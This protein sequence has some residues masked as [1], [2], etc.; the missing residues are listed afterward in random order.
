MEAADVEINEQFS[1]ALGI[2][3][4]GRN[5]F[6][7]GKAGTGK[8]TLLDYFRNTTKK[9]VAVLAP[10]GVAA[11]NING[12][13][14]HSFFGFGPDIT[15]DK[16]KIFKGEQKELYNIVEAIV[17]DEVSMVRADLL[18]C[19]DRFLRLNRTDKR[20]FGGI[21]MVFF[22]DLYQL[23]PVV[24]GKEKEI[25]RTHYKSQYFFDSNVFG[26]FEMELLEL[27][28]I[29]R[30][31]DQNFIDILNAIRNN[32]VLP[33]Q[34]KE[35]NKRLLPDFRPV[36]GEFYINLTT[37]NDM[38]LH[39]NE[40]ELS[41]LKTKL[42][43]Y[44]GRIRGNFDQKYLPTDICLKVK[45]GSQIMLLNNDSKGRWVNGTIGKV[46]NIVRKG[47]EDSIITELQNGRIVDIAPYTWKIYK[48]LY[49][50]ETRSLDSETVGSFTQYPLKLA[51]AVTIHKGQ[52]KTFDKVIIDI[53]KGTF[54]H[55]QAYVALSRC[56][57][58]D[59][60]VLKKPIEKKHI[61][62]DWKIVSFITKYQYKQAEKALSL[63]EKISMIENAIKNKSKLNIVYLKSND[64]KSKRIVLP[65]KVGE[66]AYL[67]KSYTGMEGFC[68]SRNDDR[69]FRVDRILEISECG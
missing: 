30:Q 25:F 6:V 1:K 46:A 33:G 47:K 5:V 51:W 9:K 19:V 21:Q 62:T 57:S 17:I 65:K 59:G 11:V 13:T 14:I 60:I 67:G 55:G 16:V 28:K 52:G 43:Y 34:L 54:V 61:F 64:Q 56:T 41:K 29:Y 22:G 24:V 3:E 40:N 48:M 8:S 68:Y 35:I 7:T 10:T 23:P 50:K 66:M 38:A 63:K 53:G 15:P 45:A 36:N 42:F 37:T 31:K 2:I 58:L 20:P 32:S 26:A 44:K 12:Q 49:N 4:Q 39:A 18:D 69:T 27:E